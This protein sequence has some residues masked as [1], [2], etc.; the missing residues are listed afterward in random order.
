MFDISAILQCLS[1]HLDKKTLRQLGLI[2]GAMLAMTGRM[3][4]LGISRWTERGG[5][6]RTIQRFFNGKLLWCELHWCLLRSHLVL[7][8]EVYL[9]AGDEVVVTKAGKQTF[10]LNRF[11]SSLYGRPVKGLC[12][13]SLSLVSVKRRS[14]YPLGCWQ[15]VRCAEAAEPAT[16]ERAQDKPRK[17][18]GRPKGS[19]N[20]D[21]VNVEFGAHLRFV[22]DL[23]QPVLKLVRSLIGVNYL[24]LDGAYGYNEVMQLARS[25]ELSLISKLKRNAALYL[26]YQGEQKA[27]G[28]RRKYGE[29]LDYQRIP[30]TYLQSTTIEAGVQTDIYQLKALHKEFAGPLN[31]VVI[32]KTKLSSGERAHVVLFSS[33]LTL[34]CEQLIEYYSLR[35]QLE[36]N[37]RDA[38]Q[39]WGLEDFM[40]LGEQPI[41]NAANL[42]LFMVNVSK[43]L[44]NQ[45]KP[46]QAKSSV[47]D[48]KAHFRAEKYALET[49]KLL[50]QKPDAILIRQILANIPKIGAI[51]A[52]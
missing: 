11:F 8:D 1:A 3:S 37:F 4:M 12:F 21:K 48:L 33:D 14:S 51:R 38:K 24:V 35:F 5:S 45:P 34:A 50:P 30:A 42:S 52:A 7:E 9:L 32:L 41:H 47:L 17:A 25:L 15:M 23:L 22:Q 18:R 28:S 26:P 46:C 44:L 10:G 19:K 31:V 2:V 40:N 49:L 36:F 39:F 6:Y 43:V 20:R 29:K 16:G 27:R 13:F